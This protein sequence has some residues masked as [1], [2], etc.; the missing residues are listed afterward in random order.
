[1]DGFYVGVRNCIV[2]GGEL[3]D[4]LVI[5]NKIK[6]LSWEWFLGK[7]DGSRDTCAYFIA[8]VIV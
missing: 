3:L 8:S 7:I 5:M 6:F 1:M 2:S 4:T